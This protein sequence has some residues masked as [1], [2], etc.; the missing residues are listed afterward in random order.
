M[1]Y[2]FGAGNNGIGVLN[3]FGKENIIA[4]IDN[5]SAKVGT[6][7][8]GVKIISYDQFLKQWNKETVIITAYRRSEEI[9]EQLEK[10]GI[11]SY[12][13][14]PYLQN[15]FFSIDEIIDTW[16]LLDKALII[17][18]NNPIL[19]VLVK[20]I[21]ER[22]SKDCNHY[23]KSDELDIFEYPNPCTLLTMD[24]NLDINSLPKF[25]RVLSLWDAVEKEKEKKYSYLEAFH[26]IR[27]GEKCFL[28]G[29]GP[30]LRSEDLQKIS[31]KKIPSFGCN[32]INKI[33]EQTDWRPDY[34]VV[35]DNTVYEECKFDISKEEI[36]FIANSGNNMIEVENVYL[37]YSKGEKYCKGFPSFS[38][39]IVEGIYSGLTVMYIMLQI[40]V[41]M[42]FKEIYLLGVDFSWGEDGRDTHFCKD[43]MDDRLVHDAMK[44]K[45]EQKNAYISARRYAD[46][47]GIKIYNATRGGHL[48]VF[49]RVD[50]DKIFEVTKE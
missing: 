45:E 46:A 6:E 38:D 33:Y 49:E 16:N 20:R 44:Y 7:Y 18:N 17:Y 29:N 42:G 27:Y 8:G 5:Q 36:C 13:I 21:N 28:V 22:T 2:L 37:Y 35:Q 15:G 1:F 43:Y 31:E 10:D 3:Y 48:E 14:C 23:I 34:Y 26:N 9:V 39:N 50:F 11:K 47:H 4:F 12:Y 19:E 41:Y 24:G 32:R 25:V 30:S 40:A